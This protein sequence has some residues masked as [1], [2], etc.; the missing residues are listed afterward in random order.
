MVMKSLLAEVVDGRLVLPDEA[1]EMLPV[2]MQ[3]RVV[4]DS[5]KGT[6]CVYAKDPTVLSPD[7]LRFMDALAELSEDSTNEEYF[8]VPTDEQLQEIKR[9]RRESKDSE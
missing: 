1:L 7:T 8:A 9:K 4:T 3:L 5:E 6:V 2:G